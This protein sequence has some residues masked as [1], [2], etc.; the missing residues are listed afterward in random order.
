M[1]PLAKLFLI[2]SL[3]FCVSDIKSQ[4]VYENHQSEVYHYLYRMAQKGLI[5]FDD[6]I[7]PLSRLY[8]GNCLDSLQQKA[9]LLSALEKSEL[10]FYRK[11]FTDQYIIQN[12][13]SEKPT[14]FN[15]D[16]AGRWRSFSTISQNFSLRMDPIITSAIQTGTNKNITQY[17]SGMHLYGYAGNHWGF[18]FS[19]NDVNEKGTGLDT[20]RQFSP[21]NGI[22]TRIANNKKSQNFS[23]L[24]A[25][26]SYSWKN[27]SISFGQDNLLWGFGENGRLVLSTKSPTYPYIR[28]DYSPISWLKFNYTHAWL[29][30]NIV[31]SARS[32]STGGSTYGGQRQLFVPKYMACHSIQFTPLKGLD[33]TIGESMVYSD[34]LNAGYLLPILFF[35]AYDNLINNGNINAGSNGQFFLQASSR[36]NIPNTHI[37]TTLFIDEIRLSSL[38][39]KQKSRNQVGITLGASVTD[40]FTPYLTLGI[41]YTRIN[42]FVY[43]NLLP[44]QDYTS[45]NY[46]LGD[47]IGNNADKLIYTIRYTPIPRLKC[48]LRYQSVRKGGAGTTDQQ[49]FQQPQPSFLFDLQRK[50]KEWY[51]RISY[52]WI[53]NLYLFGYA[54]SL[55]TDDYVSGKSVTQNLLSLGLSFGL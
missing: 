4:A 38:F 22:V 19:F 36:N 7:R 27:G 9:G 43:K 18:Y 1:R 13:R 47:W 39:D 55:K 24:R 26:I 46:G 32:Y 33:L 11:D 48:M 31:D 23:E 35:K 37:Y 12:S 14:F 16:S 15:V 30:S 20:L 34:R 52:E 28:F 54:S 10:A 5:R 45:D 6:N 17:S 50:Q 41:E 40:L 53:N 8:I 44:A 21:D 49:Y 42:P 25:G 29:N 2:A 51:A 3:L